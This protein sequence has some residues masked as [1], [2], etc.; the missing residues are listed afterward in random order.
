MKQKI[1]LLFFSI[2]LLHSGVGV[3]AQKEATYWYFGDRVGMD[4][5]DVLNGNQTVPYAITGPINTWEGCF[6]ISDKDGNFLFASDGSTVYNGPLPS[7]IMPGGTGLQ[8]NSMS[9]QSGIL[10]P[11]PGAADKYFVVTVPSLELPNAGIRYSVIDLSVPGGQ[12]I[13]KNTPLSLLGSGIAAN[14]TYENVSAVSK[15]NDIDYWL[16]HRVK[17]KFLIWDVTSSGIQG[18]PTVTNIGRDLT[19]EAG[20][21][22]KVGY[23]KFSPDG[24]KIVHVGGESKWVTIA[25]FDNATGQITNIKERK[26]TTTGM[27]LYGVEFSPSG[28]YIYFCAV[29]DGNVMSL[30]TDNFDSAPVTTLPIKGAA[31]QLG[32]DHKIYTVYVANVGLRGKDLMVINNPDDGGSDISTYPNFFTVGNGNTCGLPTFVSSF[33]GITGIKVVPENPCKETPVNVSIKMS[34]GTGANAVD[35]IV[36]DFGDGTLPITENNI[37]SATY[38]QTHIY[39]KRGVYTLT[40][41]PYRPDNTVI[42]EKIKTEKIKIGSC[43]LPVNHNIS[44]MGYYD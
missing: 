38:S 11:C 26:I 42:I 34:P 39:E 23:I 1:H 41:T 6:S 35:K 9:A 31:L 28:N 14:E 24:K 8:G 5:S 17:D 7:N 30:P 15:E 12:V 21:G 13:S 20:N 25:D 29:F 36:W 10:I 40:I 27:W 16:I 43:L 44:V 32:P 19:A 22:A 18:D 37:I 4:F 33:F 2:L 3:H